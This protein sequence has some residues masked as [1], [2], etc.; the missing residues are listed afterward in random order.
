MTEMTM[1]TR[2]GMTVAGAAM[3]AFA[4]AGCTASPQDDADADGAS[5]PF[6]ACLKAAGV[7]AKISDDISGGYVLV[8]I[9]EPDPGGAVT[10][11]VDDSGG[12]APLTM[13]GDSEGVWIAAQTSA[14]F[15]DDPDTQDAYAACETAHPDFVQPDVDP[16]GSPAEQEQIAA[17]QAAALAFARCARDEGFAWVADPGPESAGGI[18]LP[19]DLTEDEFRAVLTACWDAESTGFG[20]SVPAEEPGFDWQAVLMEFTDGVGGISVTRDAG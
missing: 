3:L 20:W 18:A 10:S 9:G 15:V 14:Y 2:I 11:S 19:T 12:E 5:A 6:V 7:D 13:M 8:K 17:Q 1:R 4:A 16:A